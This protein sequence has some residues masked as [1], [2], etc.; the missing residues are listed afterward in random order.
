MMPKLGVSFKNWYFSITSSPSIRQT[1]NPNKN[2]RMLPFETEI[3][4]KTFDK[5]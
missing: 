1:V 3:K 5:V 2:E 4:Y